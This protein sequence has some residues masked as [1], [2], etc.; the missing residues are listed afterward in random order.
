M[1]GESEKRLVSLDA[2]R[3]FDMLF[4]MGFAPVVTALCGILGWGDC[5][6][7]Q[8][9][10]HVPWHGFSHHDTIFPFFLFIAGISF[11]FSLAKQLDRNVPTSRTV[12]RILYRGLMLVF[13]GWVYNGLFTKG[14]CEVRYASVLGRI[15][16]AW[17][18]AALLYLAFGLNIRI[19]MA[20]CILIGY[21]ALMRFVPVP[22]SPSDVAVWSRE[23]NLAGWIDMRCLPNSFKY[24]DPEGILS[25]LPAIVTAMLGM[26]TGEFVLSRHYGLTGGCKVLLMFAASCVLLAGGLIFSSWIPINKKIWT[27]TFVLAAGSYSLAVFTLFYGLVDVL[28]WQKWAF[29]FRV[30]G[31]NS[32][33]IYLL[34]RIVD[35]DTVSHFFFGGIAHRFSTNGAQLIIALGHVILAWLL[36]LFCYRKKI[37]VK[38]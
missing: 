16:L 31:M 8:Q 21:W 30:I 11:P 5:W 27:P 10:R 13:L 23:W 14:F 3:G 2:V 20:L 26:F 15:G 4:I 38:I 28:K 33:L 32:V 36:L 34:Q 29:F 6:I 1:D 12:G 22:G 17:M 18:F 35:F 7:V 24:G 25:T 37:F 9:M 19:L